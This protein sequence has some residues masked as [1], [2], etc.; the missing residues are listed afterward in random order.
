[1]IEAIIEKGTTIITPNRRL[2]ATLHK[3]YQTYQLKQQAEAWETPDIL[4][5]SSWIQRS[6]AQLLNHATLTSPLLLTTAQEQF[7]WEDIVAATSES[8]Q[9][10]QLAETA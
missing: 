2:S 7:I 3:L 4:P 8:L 5:V 1:M 10:L 6:S 9:L